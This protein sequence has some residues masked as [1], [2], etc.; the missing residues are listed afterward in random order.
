MRLKV[1][2]DDDEK[3]ANGPR[4]RTR[5]DEIIERILD[6]QRQIRELEK[7]LHHVQSDL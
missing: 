2:V 6:L 7:E 3:I 1:P 5:A 4:P